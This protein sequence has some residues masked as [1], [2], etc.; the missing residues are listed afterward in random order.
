VPTFVLTLAA[1]RDRKLR[2]RVRCVQTGE[3]VA[4]RSGVQLLDA[5]ENLRAVAQEVGLRPDPRPGRAD[6]GTEGGPARGP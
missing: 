5:L 2:G 3:E 6:G 4:F 1:A